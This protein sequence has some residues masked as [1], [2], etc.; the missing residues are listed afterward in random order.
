MASTPPYLGPMMMMMLMMR[1]RIRI[2]INE[3]NKGGDTCPVIPGQGVD[4]VN[5][6][7]A[8]AKPTAGGSI[9]PGDG[10]PPPEWG[11]LR[12]NRTFAVGQPWGLYG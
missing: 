2:R 10:V 4:S 5:P 8:G 1:I 6:G 9:P 12:P 7:Q 3:I 11:R